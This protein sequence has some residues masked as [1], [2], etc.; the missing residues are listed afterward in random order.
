MKNILKKNRIR[1]YVYLGILFLFLIFPILWMIIT[2]FKTNLVIYKIPPQWF[3]K[4][5]II[6]NY[7]NILK[8]KNFITYF[9]NNFITS[10]MVTLL[11]IVIATLG[12]YAFSRYRFKGSDSIMLLLLST[13]MFPVIGII[14]ALYITFKNIGLINT[15]FG[16]IL[17]IVSTTVPL[18]TWLMK[19]F[20]DSIPKALEEAAYIDGC[21]RLSAMI[22]IIIPLSSPGILAIGLYSFLLAWDDY[23]FCLTLI[24]NDKLR[25]LS[26]GISLRYL[27]ELSYD[28]AT[29]MTASVM[30][31]VPMIIIFMFLQ[32]YMIQGLTEGAIKE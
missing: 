6:D 17:A 32:R 1:T 30:G 27:G 18:C 7:L 14:L 28:W 9:L 10:V 2:S 22:K 31:S 12:G 16:L 19:S 23:L 15:R 29:V 5:P 11:T 21:G 26:T 25:T 24:T 8:D 20:F 13:Q 4:D 3:P